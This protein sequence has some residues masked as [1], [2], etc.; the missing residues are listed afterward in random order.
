MWQ[1]QSWGS[2]REAHCFSTVFWLN[3]NIL[4]VVWHFI[5]FC[6]HLASQWNSKILLHVNY[7]I[8]LIVSRP[9]DNSIRIWSSLWKGIFKGLEA[10]HPVWWAYSTVPDRRWSSDPSCYFMHVCNLLWRWHTGMKNLY[11]L[12]IILVII[13][14]KAVLLQCI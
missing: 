5:L 3:K 4:I 8:L 12:N 6:H 2:Y 13:L 1:K 10:Q 14:I 11:F 7:F 9:L